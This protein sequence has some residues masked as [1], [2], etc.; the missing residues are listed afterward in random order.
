MG[1]VFDGCDY[2]G[3]MVVN[4]AVTLVGYGTDAAEG[5]F[6]LVKNSWGSSWGEGGYIRLRRQST[7]Q[8]AIDSSPL[9]GSGC[10]MEALSPLRCAALV[11]SCP[12]TPTLL[13][14]PS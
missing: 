1:G 10:V 7:T 5:D 9:D 11:L 4:H 12:T 2:N 3:N 13:A 8:C 14:P 6:W